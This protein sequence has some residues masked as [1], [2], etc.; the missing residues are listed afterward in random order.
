MYL[1]DGSLAYKHNTLETSK[2]LV[3]ITL[4][5]Q[6]SGALAQEPRIGEEDEEKVEVLGSPTLPSIA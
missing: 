6:I 5:L 2:N 3:N 4:N 1:Q